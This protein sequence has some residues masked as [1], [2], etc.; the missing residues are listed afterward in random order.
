[1]AHFDAHLRYSDVAL[2]NLKFCCMCNKAEYM[3]MNT[4]QRTKAKGAEGVKSKCCAPSPPK[5]MF[6][7]LILKWQILMHISGILT[8]LF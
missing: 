6:D 8:Y 2:L 1:M 7:D 5:E 4:R 3:Y